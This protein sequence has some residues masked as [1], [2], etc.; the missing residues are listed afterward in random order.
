MHKSIYFFFIL[1]VSHDI[2]LSET[3]IKSANTMT[4]VSTH[5]NHD[6]QKTPALL[7]IFGYLG[8]NTVGLLDISGY[9][10]RKKSEQI[11]YSEQTLNKLLNYGIWQ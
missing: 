6:N 8:Q 11:A 9:L 10:G 5:P 4:D 2:T 3:Q 1:F 7:R